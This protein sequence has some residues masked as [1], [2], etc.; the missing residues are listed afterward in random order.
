MTVREG[1]DGL[2]VGLLIVLTAAVTLIL[3]R[4]SAAK[5]SIATEPAEGGDIVFYAMQLIQVRYSKLKNDYDLMATRAE[6]AERESA[7]W[8]ARALQ[9]G[10]HSSAGESGSTTA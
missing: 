4:R 10:W 1:L 3:V 9:S 5:V 6:L 7:L 8:E 2:A